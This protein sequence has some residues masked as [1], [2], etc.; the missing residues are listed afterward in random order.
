[1]A[2]CTVA[3]QAAGLR[4]SGSVLAEWA[5][6]AARAASAAAWTA[7]GARGH[8]R[9]TGRAFGDRS[10]ASADEAMD[11]AAALGAKLD[12]SVGHFLAFFEA[13]C[14]GVAEVFVS[15]HMFFSQLPL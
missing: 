11:V 5:V 3:S 8:R 6:V 1:M 12:G 4:N 10:R 7:T 9:C 14:A 2:L 13:G 15:G